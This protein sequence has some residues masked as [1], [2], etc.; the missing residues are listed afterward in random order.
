MRAAMAAAEVGDDVFGDDPTVNALQETIAAL[1]GKEAALF[2]RQRHAE[3]PGRR[4]WAT[5]GAA[6]STSSAR[7]RTPTAGKAAA[8]RRSAASS[9]SRSSTRADGSLRAGDDRGGDQARRCALREEP[10][11]LPREHDRRQGAAARVPARRRARSRSGAAWRRTST[12]RA[13][14]TPRSRSAAIRA[15]PRARSQRRSTASRSA[16]RRASARRSARR[17]SARAN[18]SPARTA[19]A[20][21]S[22]AACARPASLAAAALHALEHHVDRLADDHALATRLADGL[23]G[24][25]GARRSSRRRP[26][27]CSPTCDERAR[28]GP[29]GAPASRAASSRRACTAC[30]SSPTSTSMPP[31]SIAPSPRCANTCTERALN[32][33]EPPCRSRTPTR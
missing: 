1:L 25:A 28:A 24:I 6:T 33:P 22:A 7:W 23:A 18:S 31:A 14:S 30:A 20:R 8:R 13:S 12:A 21:W 17:W 15:R 5:A 11:A 26:T 2:V 29:A 32:E 4:S 3:Q 27:S 10:P 9:R 16:S 19:G